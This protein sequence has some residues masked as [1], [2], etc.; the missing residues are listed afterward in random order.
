QQFYGIEH[1][2][3]HSDDIDSD[4]AKLKASGARILEELTGMSG[5]KV[6]F[7]EDPYG[8]QFEVSEA[9]T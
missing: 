9:A 3:L 7:L 8:I 1:I 6:F 4:V 5:Q 2:G